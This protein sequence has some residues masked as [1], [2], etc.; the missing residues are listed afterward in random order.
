MPL[1]VNRREYPNHTPE[2]VAGYIADALG[3]VAEFEL[4]EKLETALVL[5]AIDLLASKQ[6]TF[7][8]VMPAGMVL[9]RLP[10]Q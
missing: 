8:Q 10:P 2:Q 5:K 6:V 9:P 7:E 1:A 4:D 3:L